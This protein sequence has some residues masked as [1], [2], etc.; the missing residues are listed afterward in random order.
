MYNVYCAQKKL[1]QYLRE[2]VRISI[3]RH[4]INAKHNNS[5]WKKFAT[6]FAARH[7]DRACVW[8]AWFDW[9][10][11]S[12]SHGQQSHVCRVPTIRKINY[13]CVISLDSKTV[14]Y[15]V[16]SLAYWT[17]RKPIRSASPIVYT[18]HKS[19]FCDVLCHQH[20]PP[21]WCLSWE[22]ATGLCHWYEWMRTVSRT[23]SKKT[24]GRQGG[25]TQNEWM[26]E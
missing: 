20:S 19:K 7:E 26:N 21:A 1:M 25:I 14:K 8:A 15:E 11:G 10:K 9:R 13:F 4:S 12:W 5:F 24:S 2:N 6:L 18:T 22:I 17:N 23:Y 3:V 16:W